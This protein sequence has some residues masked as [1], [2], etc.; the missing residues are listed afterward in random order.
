MDI[1]ML[2]L[3]IISIVLSGA[4]AVGFGAFVADKI[5][6]DHISFVVFLT[7]GFGGGAA[8]ML[9]VGAIGIWL[10]GVRL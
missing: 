8:I 4:C 3:W 10:F 7:I 5:D 2:S 6:S 9:L 1:F